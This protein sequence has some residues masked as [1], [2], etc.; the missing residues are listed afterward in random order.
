MNGDGKWLRILTA[1]G[2]YIALTKSVETLTTRDRVEF[3]TRSILNFLSL[4]VL[5]LRPSVLQSRRFPRLIISC[6]RPSVLCTSCRLCLLRLWPISLESLSVLHSI[7]QR[8]AI[9]FPVRERTLSG[10]RYKLANKKIRFLHLSSTTHS[11]LYLFLI[12]NGSCKEC[13]CYLQLRTRRS[14]RIPSE[15][16]T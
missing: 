4:P 6:I 14:V 15:V 11:K 13:S 10:W 8:S 16:R 2:C 12:H 7:S 1:N 5:T 9:D 3:S